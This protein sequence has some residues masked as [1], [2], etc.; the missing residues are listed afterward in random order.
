MDIG[1]ANGQNSPLAVTLTVTQLREVIRQEVLSVVA[2]HAGAPTEPTKPYLT[3]KEAA[4]VA[5]IAPSTVRLYI[6]KRELRAQRVG[7]RVIIAAPDLES[8]LARNCLEAR[9]L[10]P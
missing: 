9:Q 8:F 2:S 5:R 1:K 7:R 6:R 4:D 3:V 10:Y